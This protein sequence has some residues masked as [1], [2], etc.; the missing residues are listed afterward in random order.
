MIRPFFDNY[1]ILDRVTDVHRIVGNTDPA[2]EVLCSFR[3][4]VHM[5]WLKC[6]VF[7]V[8]LDYLVWFNLEVD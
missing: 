7:I 3:L 8:H 2:L 4:Q 6:G 1:V 5:V